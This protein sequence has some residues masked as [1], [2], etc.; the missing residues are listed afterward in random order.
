MPGFGEGGFTPNVFSVNSFY[1]VSG[2]SGNISDGQTAY[3]PFYSYLGGALDQFELYILG[4]TFTKLDWAIMDHT[5]GGAPGSV[6]LS[7][8]LSN[9]TGWVGLSLG[10]GTSLASQQYYLLR[11]QPTGG[12]LSLMSPQAAPYALHTSYSPP[13][14]VLNYSG[15][16]WSHLIGNS[17]RHW[18]FMYRV[19]GV[20]FGQPLTNANAGSPLYGDKIGLSFR[21]DSTLP[22]VGAVVV[23]ATGSGSAT[24]EVYQC[25]SSFLPTGSPVTSVTVYRT[26]AAVTGSQMLVQFSDA[27]QLQ[28]FSIVVSP[29]HSNCVYSYDSGTSDATRFDRIW[30]TCV[31]YGSVGVRGV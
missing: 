16:T 18:A 7:G 28:N 29:V 13:T 27:V 14:P 1:G 6:L 19:G 26:P 31:R 15:G 23:P 12:S 3:L 24:V 9:T 21:L 5:A 25:D 22:I 10:I 4:A 8:T 30:S 20:W 17:Y 2:G 11:L